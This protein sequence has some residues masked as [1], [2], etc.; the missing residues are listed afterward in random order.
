MKAAWEVREANSYCMSPT[1]DGR[2]SNV[3]VR[4]GTESSEVTK[5]TPVT[6]PD[7]RHNVIANAVSDAPYL[8]NGRNDNTVIPTRDTDCINVFDCSRSMCMG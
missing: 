3:T 8:R 5:I 1:A 4:F 7:C 6:A 2:K